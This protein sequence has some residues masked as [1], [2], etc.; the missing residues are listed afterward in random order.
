MNLRTI[1]HVLKDTYQEWN[2]DKASTLAAALAYYTIFSVG[3]LLLIAVSIAGLV[4]GE[5][6]A[7]GQIV[8]Q[9]QG[10]VGPQAAEAIQGMLQATNKPR[11]GIV[12]TAIG[13]VTLLLGA[14]GFFGQLQNALNIIWK[15][16]PPARSIMGTVISRGL[17]FLMVLG[18]GVMLLALLAVSAAIATVTA[19]F[20]SLLPGPAAGVVLGV[21]D[22]VV[23]FAVITVLFAVIYRVLPD[24]TIHLRDVWVG[25]AFTAL[26]FTI[27]KMALGIYLGTASV[28]SAFGA[29]GSLV[30]LLVWI[31]YSAQIFLFGAEFTQVYA[32]RYGPNRV[33][34]E[35]T[36]PEG[37]KEIAEQGR[38]PEVRGKGSAE[39]DMSGGKKTREDEA[40]GLS[41]GQ[42]RSS[43]L[44]AGLLQATLVLGLVAAGLVTSC[45]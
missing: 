16:K 34:R 39:E 43:P 12:G 19:F 24:I 28:G 3:P 26:L 33:S 9:I 32:N 10:W 41:P 5:K 20:G 42:R 44:R 17:T 31:Y 29:A 7:Q 8:V 13:I 6:A 18:M 15:A 11:E 23:S 40:R 4:F 27:G 38:P 21:V 22:F 35:N 1:F 14:A 37:A 30:L 2:Q 25:A 36:S 45:L